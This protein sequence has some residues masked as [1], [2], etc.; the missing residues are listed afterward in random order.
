MAIAKIGTDTNSGTV[1]SL[2]ASFSHTLVTGSDRMVAVYIAVENDNTISLNTV[3]YGGNS[4]IRGI[5]GISGS[6]PYN[7]G[8]IWCL[9]END[10]PTDGS[11]TVAV[12]VSGTSLNPKLFVFCAEYTGI[13][14]GL[15]ESR[16]QANQT[17][18][19]TITN[20]LSPSSGSWVLSAVV[21]GV[22]AGSFT[23]SG[24]QT[25]ILDD[26]GTTGGQTFSITE[27]RGASGE[28][29]LSSTS[30]ITINR[31]VRV[32]LS[33]RTAVK[34]YQIN[35]GGSADSPYSADQF[36]SGGT[37]SSTGTTITIP[38]ALVNPAPPGVYQ[39]ERYGNTT[40]TIT[41]LTAYAV[42]LVR[43]HF[44]EIYWSAAGA[45]LFDIT[46]NGT[47]VLDNFDIYVAA[48]NANMTAVIR[49][50][51]TTA[52]SSGQ[53]III[54]TGVTDNAT[55]MGIEI[56]QKN[57]NMYVN[58]N[59]TWKPVDNTYINSSGTWK[60]VQSSSVNSSGTWKSVL[61]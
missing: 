6:G 22:N 25:E 17:T 15:I 16:H 9:Y 34:V 52:N 21:L 23:H 26:A 57:T 19:E 18:G 4:M 27:L 32:A 48:G 33:V 40:Y 11:K 5:G 56:I 58:V 44:A 31:L 55:N 35:T 49:E 24:S 37:V 14:Y 28:T 10:L 2:S 54:S 7:I 61:S 46:V 60:M 45:R 12:S 1:T 50:F 3:T 20:T 53:V 41:G 36:Y 59:G 39:T 47:L 38:D 13:F 51:T 43:I 8:E 30:S 42:Y 29:S